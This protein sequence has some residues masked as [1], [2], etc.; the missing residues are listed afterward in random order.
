[1]QWTRLAAISK[2][3]AAI[4]FSHSNLHKLDDS[5]GISA[6]ESSEASDNGAP[7]GKA[8]L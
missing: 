6:P 3:S 7:I 8:R 1:M 2:V 5:E 4:D